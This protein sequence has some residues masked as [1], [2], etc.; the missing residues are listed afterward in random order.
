MAER[1]KLRKQEAQ[2]IQAQIERSEEFSKFTVNSIV[3]VPRDYWGKKY[4]ENLPPHITSDFIYGKIT[5]RYLNAAQVFFFLD[6]GSD[7]VKYEALSLVYDST[8]IELG[9]AQ[10]LVAATVNAGTEEEG[11][12]NTSSSSLHLS[13]GTTRKRRSLVR[14]PTYADPDS[15]SDDAD[16]LS[17]DAE[18]LVHISPPK[19]QNKGTKSSKKTLKVKMYKQKRA[20]ITDITAPPPPFVIQ[21][22]EYPTDS[23]TSSSEEETSDD[24]QVV[25]FQY[26]GTSKKEWDKM[27]TTQKNQLKCQVQ[28]KAWPGLGWT[29]D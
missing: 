18:P 16:A 10:S 13:A 6:K 3:K 19:K 1:A 8:E 7:K 24:D 5:I 26:Y 20:K 25:D 17:S 23:E 27:S 29:T 14:K 4:A 12:V 21:E 15:E 2:A 28:K 9:S 11:S 22:S